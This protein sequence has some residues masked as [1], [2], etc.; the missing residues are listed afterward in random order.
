[1]IELENVGFVF[2]KMLSI[3]VV[4]NLEKGGLRKFG[5]EE[6]QENLL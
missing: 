3:R 6:R 4:H 5:K 2:R 1:M